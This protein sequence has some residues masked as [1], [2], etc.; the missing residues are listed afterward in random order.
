MEESEIQEIE[1]GDNNTS[2]S[3]EKKTKKTK[4]VKDTVDMDRMAKLKAIQADVEKRFGK[5]VVMPVDGDSIG[6][7]NFIST[8]LIGL[9]EALGGGYPEGRIIEIFGPESS[10][11]TTLALEAIARVQAKGGFALFV[12][13]ENAIDL[14]YA[15]DLGVQLDSDKFILSQPETAEQGLEVIE[16]YI[17]SGITNI[18]VIDSASAMVPRAE[19]EGDFGDSHMGLQARLMSQALR[20]LVGLIKKTNTVV[21]FLEQ[22]RSKIGVVFGNPEVAAGGGNSLKFYSS[23]RIDIRKTETEKENGKDSDAIANLIRVKVVKNKVAPP[24]RNAELKIIF[25]KGL[26]EVNDLVNQAVKYNVLQ[27][28]GSWFSFGEDRWQGNSSVEKV[29]SEDKELYDRIYEATKKA[30]EESKKSKS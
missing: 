24:F 20:K 6:N 18:V 23:Q 19:L 25:G 27:K 22:L 16:S 10:G 28:S 8:G 1:L 4:E 9:D 26:D 13:Y 17:E 11:K 29:L 7:V 2:L 12:D 3:K 30:I 5:G 21:I 15:R 14:N